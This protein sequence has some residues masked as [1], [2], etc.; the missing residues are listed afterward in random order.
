MLITTTPDLEGRRI[1]TYHGV[2]TGEA[3]IGA[4]FLNG[5]PPQ[6]G[7]AVDDQ[8]RGRQRHTDRN[9]TAA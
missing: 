2:V 9:P 1:R 4:N 8:G 5:A 6:P 7:D 3:I